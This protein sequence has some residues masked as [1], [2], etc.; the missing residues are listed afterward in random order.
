MT[1]QPLILPPRS[2]A[3][4]LFDLDGTLA[5]SMPLHFRSWTQAVEEQGW[6]FPEEL[7]MPGAASLYRERSKC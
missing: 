4:Y 7:F 5:D 6:T 1:A 2:F 3:A